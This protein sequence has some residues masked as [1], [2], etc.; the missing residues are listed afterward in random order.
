M[1]LLMKKTNKKPKYTEKELDT[2]FN[3]QWENDVNPTYLEI[4]F[5]SNCNF[6]CSYC[7][8]SFSTTWTKDINTN[9]P[10]QNLIIGIIN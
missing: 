5:D 10:Y 3:L 6:A 9:G 8:A 1:E 7:N 4:S 2:A